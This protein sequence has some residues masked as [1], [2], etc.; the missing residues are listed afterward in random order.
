VV[1]LH[2]RDGKGSS[3]D[4]I[5][6]TAVA[7]TYKKSYSTIIFVL[8]I[9]KIVFSIASSNMSDSKLV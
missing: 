9:N 1:K 6:V 3:G 8:K 5:L 4:S 7:V 2:D